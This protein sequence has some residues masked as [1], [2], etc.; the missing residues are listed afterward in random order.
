[1][2]KIRRLIAATSLVLGVTVVG[3]GPASALSLNGDIGISVLGIPLVQLS[4]NG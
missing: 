1:M 2:R 3:A 4:V